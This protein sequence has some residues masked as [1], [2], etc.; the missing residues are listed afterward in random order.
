MSLGATRSGPAPKE[1]V[2]SGAVGVGTPIDR[3]ER[4]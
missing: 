4:P 1:A 2:M 3:V